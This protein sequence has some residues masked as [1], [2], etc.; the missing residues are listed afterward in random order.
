MK[1]YGL[2]FVQH[3]SVSGE[4]KPEAGD[5]AGMKVKPKDTDDDKDAHQKGDVEI[6][7][8]L[9]KEGKLFDKEKVI[10]PYP[11]CWR[12]ET[13]LLNYAAS[14]WFVKVTDFKDRMVKENAKIKW[15]PGSV[16][17]ARFGNWLEGARDWAIS[18]TRFWGA[19]IPV[20][21]EEKTGKTHVFS[22][23]ADLKK[24]SRAKNEYYVM[25]HGQA[26]NNVKNILDS[27]ELDKDHPSHL[28]VLGKKQALEAVGALRKIKPDL[29][30]VSPLARTRETAETLKKELGWKEGQIIVDDRIREMGMGKWNGRDIRD[31]YKEA[32]FEERF[33]KCAPDGE[34]YADIK[35]RMGDFLYDVES[36]HEGKRILVISHESPIFLLIAAAMGMD[37]KQSLR[38]RGGKDFIDNAEVRKVDFHPLPHN[39][40]YELDLHRPFIDDIELGTAEGNKL[41]R[42]PDVFDCWFESGAMPY[43]EAHY[44]F[45]GG[46]GREEGAVFEPRGHLFRKSSGYPADFI[47]EGLD[48]TR[49]WFYSML[50]LGVGLFKKSPYKN[51]IVNGLILAEDG[52]KMAKSKNNYPDPMIVV[53]KYGAD[54]LRHY[55]MASQAVRGEE[56]CFSEKG[57]DEVTKKIVNRLLNVVSFYEMYGDKS[58]VEGQES[59]TDSRNVLDIWIMARLD[60]LTAS[61]G[62]GLESYE[63]DKAARPIEDFVD[64]L[65]T[66]YLRRSR[67]RFR[68][69]DATDKQ[70]ALATTRV[71]LLGLAKSVAPFMPFLAEEVYKRAGG[72]LESVHLE[73]W[74]E[75]NMEAEESVF[76]GME[77]VRSIASMALMQR[78]ENKIP[79]RQP[80]PRLTVKHNGKAPDFWNAGLEHI[81]KDEVN[82]KEIVFG[83]SLG[84][85]GLPIKL[86]TGITPELKEEGDVRELVRKIQDLR[87]EKGLSMKDRASLTAPED[88]K[89]L[90]FKHEPEIKKATN[91]V[92]IEYG[93]ELAIKA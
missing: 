81:L 2:P 73:D 10:H 20:W 36:K 7:K 72:K 23:V 91:I 54:S 50:A 71:V 92:S 93:G 84:E 83:G 4:F 61:V 22:S 47:A 37:R 82:V 30:F 51:V 55:L 62:A 48:Q 75:A 49:G 70:A 18:R 41:V 77:F 44:P 9:A 80:L 19:P 74:P 45:E 87:K 85:S 25:R 59:G 26:D 39:D 11:H 38:F 69:D 14:S 76:T 21:R 29:V 33:T 43:G 78:M 65:S 86:D 35:R 24:F 56:L 1:K 67:D 64:D 46:A 13:P 42:V 66:W 53:E 27:E 52:T 60:Q 8:W 28:T 32:H 5:F 12:C 3:V 34:N 79:V 58:K 89:S 16:G 68:G 40:E 63:L 15:V 88:L 90:I 6:I 57:V 31:F 17:S